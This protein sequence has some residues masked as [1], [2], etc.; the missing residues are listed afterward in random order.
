MDFYDVIEINRKI[1]DPLL[2][3]SSIRLERSFGSKI[4]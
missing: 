2:L 3:K 1:G 4:H